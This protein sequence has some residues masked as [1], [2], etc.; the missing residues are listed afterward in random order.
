MDSHL[1]Y[2]PSGVRINR[3]ANQAT[4]VQRS[5]LPPYRPSQFDTATGNNN[6]T[7]GQPSRNNLATSSPQVPKLLVQ[8]MPSNHEFRAGLVDDGVGG[9]RARSQTSSS[10]TSSV[11]AATFSPRPHLSSSTNPSTPTRSPASS[12]FV[13][14]TLEGSVTSTFPGPTR[15][16]S[17]E[18]FEAGLIAKEKLAG[19][20]SLGGDSQPVKMSP[21]SKAVVPLKGHNASMSFVRDDDDDSGVGLS[22]FTDRSNKR[23]PLTTRSTKIS[24]LVTR[25]I[26]PDSSKSG[27]DPSF[28]VEDPSMSFQH[29]SD[30][31]SLFNT[32]LGQLE[33]VGGMS[34]DELAIVDEG[35]KSSSSHAV[36]EDSEKENKDPTPNRDATPN[37]A[38][39]FRSVVDDRSPLEDRSAMFLPGT[40]QHFFTAMDNGGAVEGRQLLWPVDHRPLANVGRP[41]AFGLSVVGHQVIP[42][43][44]SDEVVYVPGNH[45]VPMPSP[46]SLASLSTQIP[47]EELPPSKTP[48]SPFGAIGE[49]R[50]PT[51]KRTSVERSATLKGDVTVKATN[52]EGLGL[53]G[54]T[55][56]QSESAS[57][58]LYQVSLPPSLSFGSR[59]ISFLT[60]APQRVPPRPSS[61]SFPSSRTASDL[62]GCTPHTVPPAHAPSFPT[63]CSKPPRYHRDFDN[64][65]S[66]LSLQTRSSSRERQAN[67]DHHLDHD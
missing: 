29:G 61:T 60:S 34:G 10:R 47:Y 43:D 46:A 44:D 59:L 30:E 52:S 8:D 11:I 45:S 33:L 57:T 54:M 24:P 63:T 41:V 2:A 50:S 67:R 22:P 12:V 25:I 55:S 42:A 65:A 35:D 20:V 26:N 23:S 58:S 1:R 17:Y 16:P 64:V 36:T 37:R 62:P 5:P 53:Q 56:V 19:S 39:L 49:S 27:S 15:Q 38:G 9:A 14:K 51:S 3:F 21:A 18:T 31:S 4:A 7:P 40:P 66:C 32:S 6:L 48:S 13:T 28:E